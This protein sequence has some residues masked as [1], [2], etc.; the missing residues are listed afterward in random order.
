MTDILN[1]TSP[2]AAAMRGLASG[3]MHV[4]GIDG[5][6]SLSNLS[7]C[8]VG[9]MEATVDNDLAASIIAS[10]SSDHAFNVGFDH[11]LTCHDLP[12]LMMHGNGVYVS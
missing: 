2:R 5:A 9:F 12:G 4:C 8:S 3:M 1:D 10:S 11:A 7:R 6:A